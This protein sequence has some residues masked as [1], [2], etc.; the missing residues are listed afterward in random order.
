M[1]DAIV[2]AAT[3][4]IAYFVGAIPFGYL[5]ARMHG[6]DI[7]K[8]GSGSIGAT[9]VGRILGWGWGIG[10]FLLDFA[11]GAGPAAAG[12]AIGRAWAIEPAAAAGVA[13]GLAAFLGHLFPIYLRFHG[14]KG[15]AT[16]AGVVTVL[17]PGPTLA[18]LAVWLVVVSTTLFM[19][20][21][22]LTGA[23]A[24]CAVYFATQPEPFA[25]QHLILTVF[26]L[27]ATAL[28]F[29]KHRANIGRLVRGNENRLADCETMRQISKVIHV[30]AVGLWFGMAVFFSF[31]VALT[32]FGSFETLAESKNRPTWFPLPEAYTL[33]LDLQKEQGIRAAGFA[34]SPRFGHYFLWQG[35]CGL[36]AC[37]TALSWSRAEPGRRIHSLRA[38]VVLLALTTV[39]LGW[40]VEQKVGELR[41][42]RNAAADVL[43]EKLKTPAW[44]EVPQER[45]NWEAAKS[46]FARWHLWSLSLN[47]VTIVLVGLAMAMTI[48]LP[49]PQGDLRSQVA[50][51]AKGASS[52]S[53]ATSS[54]SGIAA[55]PLSKQYGNP[56]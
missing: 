31:P 17:L 10:V 47:M 21:A 51:G 18:A 33:Q 45:A 9:N 26:S 30:M 2:I 52:S 55:P 8:Q 16:G 32:L 3:A 13:A 39:V 11:K 29:V 7:F 53:E 20:I 34:I 56:I 4:I 6:I 43:I 36:L 28:V 23:V 40:P 48:A 46:E 25:R 22:S 15:V 54:R 5:A 38:A 41:Q 49:G 42:T 37:V 14:G 50:K 1:N 35:I 19:S 24:L 44:S 12:L 27:V